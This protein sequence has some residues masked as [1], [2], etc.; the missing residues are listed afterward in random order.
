MKK[1]EQINKIPIIILLILF[2]PFL[3]ILKTDILDIL[4]KAFPY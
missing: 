4:I 2:P 1:N 3:N